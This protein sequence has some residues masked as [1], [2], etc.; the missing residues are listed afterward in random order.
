MLIGRH[1]QA[2]A[3][4]RRGCCLSLWFMMG[5]SPVIQLIMK[6]SRCGFADDRG[7][8]GGGNG[9]RRDYASALVIYPLEVYHFH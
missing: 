1:K 7:W 6:W 9:G 8:D 4:G 5:G 3:M 2:G